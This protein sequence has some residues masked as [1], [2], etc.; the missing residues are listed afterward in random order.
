MQI[1]SYAAVNDAFPQSVYDELNA[2]M[3]V[4]RHYRSPEGQVI[5]LYIGYYG[6]AKGGRTGHNPYACQ[7]G[8]G[9][10][11]VRDEKVKIYVLYNDNYDKVNYTT[12]CK[13]DLYNV[14]LHW[15]HSSG[16][17]ILDSG[18]ERN[19]QRFVNR[20]TKN[21]NDG[22]FI[23]VSMQV[24]KAQVEQAFLNIKKFA[25]QIIA[26]LPQYWPVEKEV[27]SGIFSRTEPAN[28]N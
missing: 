4:Y 16:T 26:E 20:I 19:I 14:M 21:R 12:T 7:P 24:Q 2:D 27:E 11:V 17:E 23:Q 8:A 25:E 6:T 22:A 18:F 13:G 1:G 10:G 15:Y 5:D 9:W 28:R 3:H